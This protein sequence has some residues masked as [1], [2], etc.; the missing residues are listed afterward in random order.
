M[1]RACPVYLINIPDFLC[2]VPI[3]RTT[4][5]SSTIMIASSQQPPFYANWLWK[6]PVSMLWSQN[7]CEACV[8][9]IIS[10]DR[11][12]DRHHGCQK[13]GHSG[14]ERGLNRTD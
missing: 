1:G 3:E 9:P 5:S 11:Q 7:G 8:P 13:F 10:L 6:P 14:F 2:T 12:L 4:S